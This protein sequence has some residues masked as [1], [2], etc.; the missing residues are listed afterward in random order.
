MAFPKNGEISPP[1]STTSR[2]DTSL[3]QQDFT[4]DLGL[5]KEIHSENMNPKIHKTQLILTSP[6]KET[7]TPCI[8]HFWLQTPTFW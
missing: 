1:C 7:E 4:E 2:N 6:K 5:Q 8:L 3:F